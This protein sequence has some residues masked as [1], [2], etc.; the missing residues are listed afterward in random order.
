VDYSSLRSRPDDGD[1]HWW[2]FLGIGDAITRP[3]KYIFKG[4]SDA[5]VT[6]LLLLEASPTAASPPANIPFKSECLGKKQY[7]YIKI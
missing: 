2:P 5:N 3:K 6:T 1:T 4:G 7:G